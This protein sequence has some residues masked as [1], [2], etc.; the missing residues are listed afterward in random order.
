MSGKILISEE[1][2]C[3]C[4]KEVLGW[5]LEIEPGTVAL[6]EQKLQELL[7]LLDLPSTQRCIGWKDIYN[8]I[9]KLRYM[10]LVVPEGVAHICHIQCALTQ[11]GEERA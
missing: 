3:T 6:L 7:T 9:G 11:V 10:Y 8:F 4:T 1:G 5:M 2:D